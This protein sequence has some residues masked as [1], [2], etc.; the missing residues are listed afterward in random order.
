MAVSEVLTCVTAAA[1]AGCVS[2]SAVF[3][4]IKITMMTLW[5]QGSEQRGSDRNQDFTSCVLNF[6]SHSGDFFSSCIIYLCI[7]SENGF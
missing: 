7:V 1:G 6:F 5:T 3:V 4:C 2:G